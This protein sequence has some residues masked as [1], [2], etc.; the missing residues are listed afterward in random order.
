[1]CSE[2]KYEL[3]NNEV[4]FKLRKIYVTDSSPIMC[5]ISSVCVLATSYL[6]R[7]S[8]LLCVVTVGSTSSYPHA[9]TSIGSRVG[10]SSSDMPTVSFSVY[11]H[12]ATGPA[13][14][15]STPPALGSEYIQWNRTD[16]QSQT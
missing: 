8:R 6:T 9:P 2:P 5:N 16:Y 4:V 11:V 1:M 7:M 12:V 14:P 10:Y 15:F 3:L 13:Y